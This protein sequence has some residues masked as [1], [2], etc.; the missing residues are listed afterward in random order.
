MST[1]AL[2]GLLHRGAG[3]VDGALGVV[4]GLDGE[5][6]LVDGAV[7][8]AGD[9][10]DFAELDVAPDLGPLGVAVAAQS[11]AEGVG[12]GLVVAL[13]EEDLADA[14]GGERAVLVGV[15]GLLVLGDGAGEVALGDLLLA[16]QNGDA[17]GEVGRALEQPVVGIDGDAARAA[18][19][20]DG[21]VRVGA[22]DIDAAD[23]RSCRR[24]RC[25]AR[26]ACGR[27]RGPA[28]IAPT[29]R[30]PLLLPRRKT[31][32]LLVN[33]GAPVPSSHCAKKAVSSRL[34]CAS[35]TVC[36]FEVRMDLSV[37]CD[38]QG[39]EELV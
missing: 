30:K 38:E 20:L 14:V 4:V 16:A 39:A 24:S 33:A 21:V 9:V 10:E 23:L 29:V 22:G 6:V 26:P 3:F 25:A 11:V 31:V 32:Y 7:A 15:E 8:L 2:V 18:E 19:G 36:T 13:H 34:D 37:Y 17:D 28:S 5:A 1:F 27:G 12:G 35:A